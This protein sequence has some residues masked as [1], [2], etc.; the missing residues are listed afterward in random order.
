[1]RSAAKT[2]KTLNLKPCGLEPK[3]LGHRIHLEAASPDI[4]EEE[5]EANPGDLGEVLTGLGFTGFLF[6]GLHASYHKE[7]T[8][9]TKDPYYGN[10]RLP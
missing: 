5:E 6:K 4:E 9:F 8:L 7:A 10:L 1:M 3:T 2:L